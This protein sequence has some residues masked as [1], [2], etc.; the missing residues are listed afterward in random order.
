MRSGR[1][2]TFPLRLASAWLADIESDFVAQDTRIMLYKVEAVRILHVRI[3]VARG[4]SRFEVHKL[5]GFTFNCDARTGSRIKRGVVV[6]AV[7]EAVVDRLHQEAAAVRLQAVVVH[8]G[9]L[10]EA[11]LNFVVQ[12][13]ILQPVGVEISVRALTR[14]LGLEM[15]PR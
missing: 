6:E 1:D 7:A 15:L 4:I 12:H 5:G 9:K 8:A 14:P 10:A 11:E 2:N 13:G 3:A